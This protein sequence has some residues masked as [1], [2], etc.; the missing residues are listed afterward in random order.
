MDAMEILQR[1]VAADKAAR[2]RYQTAQAQAESSENRAGQLEQE[3]KQR[4]SEKARQAA[5]D[6]RQRLLDEAGQTIKEL[7]A[8]NAQKLDALKQQFETH[9]ADYAQAMFRMVIEAK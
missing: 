1:I 2:E 3:M 9:K 8:E 6:E 5:Q 4:A 7:D